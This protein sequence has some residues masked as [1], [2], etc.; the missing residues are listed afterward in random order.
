[1]GSVAYSSIENSSEVWLHRLY[2]KAGL[3][4]QG[5]GTKLLNF[6]ENYIKEQSKT[7]IHIHFGEPKE[8]WLESRCFTAILT[9]KMKIYRI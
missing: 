5:I 8:Q 2:V 4:H 7:A 1:M 3:K 9:Q 6:A